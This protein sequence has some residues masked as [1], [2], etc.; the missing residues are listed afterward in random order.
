MAKTEVGDNTPVVVVSGKHANVFEDGRAVFS[1]AC[2][3]DADTMAI[4]KHHAPG[5]RGHSAHITT[6]VHAYE[7]T[8]H[9]LKK[10]RVD[11]L[12]FPSITDA[13]LLSAMEGVALELK[14]LEASI[15]AS[16]NPAGKAA[17]TQQRSPLPG[18]KDIISALILKLP[19]EPKYDNLKTCLRA[20]RGLGIELHGAPLSTFN[21]RDALVDAFQE[22][23]DAMNYL[24]QYVM[25]QGDSKSHFD[26]Y[27]WM[28]WEIAV[29]ISDL[30][31][32]HEEVRFAERAEVCDFQ[33]VE[34][35]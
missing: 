13:E 34:Q 11:P 16:N 4:I 1:I 24:Q 26:H 22:V 33:P 23:L 31:V 25:E 21:G 27:I 2:R 28:L 10:G 19:D 29:G 9:E 5:L 20:R 14:R 15:A 30:I 35:P 32:K 7:V 6:C 18:D 8:Q 3:F 12:Y 17:I